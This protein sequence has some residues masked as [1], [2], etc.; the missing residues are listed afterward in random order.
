M[1]VRK[2]V[3]AKATVGVKMNKG[4]LH[5]LE[6]EKIDIKCESKGQRRPIMIFHELIVVSC[7]GGVKLFEISVLV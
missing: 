3:G 2:G 4:M 6:H 7:E 5:R 1:D